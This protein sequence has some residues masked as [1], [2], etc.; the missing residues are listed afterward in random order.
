MKLSRILFITALLIAAL[1]ALY[2]YP[3]MPERMAVHFNA[4]GIA[5]GFGP[6]QPF[7]MVLGIATGICFFLF[8]SFSFLMR[9]IPDSMVNLPNKSYWLAPERRKE[10]HKRLTGQMLLLGAM[11]MLLLDGVMYLCFKANLS[12]T[13]AI[14]AEILW[15]MLAL[16]M[17]ANIVIIVSILRCFRLPK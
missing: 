16:F 12:P 2:Y 7:F 4:S 15:V 17:A 3:I 1:E 9:I 10:T 11:T 5:D 14:P 6:K 8:G 13:P